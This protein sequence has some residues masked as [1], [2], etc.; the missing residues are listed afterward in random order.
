MSLI[1][2]CSCYYVSHE[3]PKIL[4]E[5]VILIA[6]Y[7]INWLCYFL[8]VPYFLSLPK[9]LD[10]FALFIIFL[11]IKTSLIL[12]LSNAYLHDILEFRKDTNILILCLINTMSV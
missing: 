2:C 12:N 3:S 10:V 6:C 11:Q 4:L 5:D 8:N 7:L 9:F 1:G